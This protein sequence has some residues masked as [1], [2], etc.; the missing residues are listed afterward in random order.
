MKVLTE[1][2]AMRMSLEEKEHLRAVAKSTGLTMT[3]VMLSSFYACHSEE[4]SDDGD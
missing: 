1:V 3:G 2:F 4:V